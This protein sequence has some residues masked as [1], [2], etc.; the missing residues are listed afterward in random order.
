[1]VWGESFW[2]GIYEDFEITL[3]KKGAEAG[4]VWWCGKAGWEAG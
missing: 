4:V 1:M 2:T 3:T